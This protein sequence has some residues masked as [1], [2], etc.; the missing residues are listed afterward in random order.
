M[1]ILKDLNDI[2]YKKLELDNRYI[3]GGASFNTV[4]LN[5]NDVKDY[6][7]WVIN[8][9]DDTSY[10]ESR[11]LIKKISDYQYMIES[12]WDY[13]P[14]DGIYKYKLY[15]YSDEI[16]ETEY[17]SQILQLIKETFLNFIE[18]DKFYFRNTDK[19]ISFRSLLGTPMNDRE[20]LNFYLVY[21][22]TAMRNRFVNLK[23]IIKE[24]NFQINE[25]EGTL[26]LQIGLECGLMNIP[27][28]IEYS[29]NLTKN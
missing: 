3:L 20:T 26:D 2:P 11:V 18:V 17:K 9:Y 12:P 8:V 15:N 22:N 27:K 21:L 1:D 29:I 16:D 14:N 13:T 7:N 10:S 24:F 4:T 23:L 19:P 5:R 25:D 6:T 28:N